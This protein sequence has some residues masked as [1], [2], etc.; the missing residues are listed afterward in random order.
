MPSWPSIKSLCPSLPTQPSRRLII[1]FLTRN[2]VKHQKH[3][4]TKHLTGIIFVRLISTD[5]SL[6]VDEPVHL[7]LYVFKITGIPCVEPDSFQALPGYTLLISPT[8]GSRIIGVGPQPHNH[9]RKPHRR[10]R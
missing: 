10:R 7:V 9:S 5:I 4:A 1:F 3:T 8:R 2:F 6:L